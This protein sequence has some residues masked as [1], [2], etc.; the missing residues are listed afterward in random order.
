MDL[1][2]DLVVLSLACSDRGRHTEFFADEAGETLRWLS[3]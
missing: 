3:Y 2:P 1:M